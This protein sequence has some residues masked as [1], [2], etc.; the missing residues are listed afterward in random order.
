MKLDNINNAM[1]MIGCG[2][3][4]VGLGETKAQK[5]YHAK[6]GTEFLQ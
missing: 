6:S 2:E 5:S 1:I 3:E 4:E